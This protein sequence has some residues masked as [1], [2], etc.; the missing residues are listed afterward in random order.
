MLEVRDT[1]DRGRGVFSV[2]HFQEGVCIER[3]PVIEIPEDEIIHI[4]RTVIHNYFFKWGNE[5][6]DGAIAL[7]F[8]SLFNHS[9]NPNAHYRLQPRERI[10]AF[11]SL[12]PIQP[13][14]EITINYNGDPEDHARLWFIPAEENS[15][16]V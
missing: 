2:V 1:R 11:Y 7:G 8:G 4:R 13:G 10:I 14:E 9:Y 5:L 16:I 15:D 3:S 12:R 6:K